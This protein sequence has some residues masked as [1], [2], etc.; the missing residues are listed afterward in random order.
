MAKK[1]VVLRDKKRRRLSSLH[2]LKRE[3]YTSITKDQSM[4]FEDRLRAQVNLSELARDSSK[5]RCR[6]RCQI[7][8]RPRGNLRKFGLSRMVLRDMASWG[9]VP[10][11]IKSSW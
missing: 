10:G 5:S 7:T 3:K 6:N 8:G 4:S 2:E 11:L 9:S 1:S